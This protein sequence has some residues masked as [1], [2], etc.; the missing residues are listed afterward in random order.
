MEWCSK[1]IIITSFSKI[2]KF[3]IVLKFF[4]YCP[5]LS[6]TIITG[7]RSFSNLADGLL[8]KNPETKNVFEHFLYCEM[9]A[10]SVFFYMI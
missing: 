4:E 2:L 1:A 7:Q 6:L 8:D 5:F 3:A 10:L 9:S